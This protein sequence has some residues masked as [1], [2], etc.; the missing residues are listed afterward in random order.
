LS[1]TNPNN[2][3]SD[4]DGLGDWVETIHGTDPNSK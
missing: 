2:P 3:D 4:G 1:K